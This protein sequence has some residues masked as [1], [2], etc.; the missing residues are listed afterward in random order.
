MKNA[1]TLRHVPGAWILTATVALTLGCGSSNKSASSG[2]DGSLDNSSGGYSSGA[3]S[4]SSGGSL[5]DGSSSGSSDAGPAGSSSGSDDGGPGDSSGGGADGSSGSSSGGSSDANSSSDVGAETGSTPTLDSGTKA[6][7][8]TKPD[9]GSSTA[10]VPTIPTVAWTSPYAGW[11]RGIPTDPTFFPIAVWLQLPSHA[12]ELA[13]LGVNIYLGNNAGTDPLMAGDLA[14][15]KGLGMYAI[16]GQDSVGLPNKDDTTIIGWWMSPDEP[17]NAQPDDGGYG[18][19]VPP[20][21]LVTE[22]NS[23]K[24]ADPTRPMYLGL[25]QGVAYPN[26]EGR[27][28][29]APAESGYVPASDIIAFDIY[30]YNNCSG[31]ANE[32]VTC[33]EFWLNATGIDNLHQWANRNQAAWTDFETTVINAG[34]TDGP[35]PVQTASEVWLALIHSANGVIYF[36]DSWNP[37]FRE[38]AI[39]E[40]TAMV[41]AVTALNQQIKSLAPELNSA[42]IPN[43]VAVASSN[44]AAPVDTMVKANGTSIY[45]FSAISRAGTATASYTIDGMTGN[46]VATVVGENRSVNVT[47]GKFSDSFAAN[48]VHI[49]KIDLSTA[50]CN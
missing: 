5:D 36:I 16:I 46:A 44:A 20:A 43:I 18:P 29:N 49:Y 3:T 50:T 24:T 42:N 21:T 2:A 27:G 41:T 38:D 6:D 9:S 10:C 13:N 30:P 14:T 22:Y 31:D 33:G 19:D 28:S 34:T 45:V 12:T 7:G 11:T 35:T 48:G 4:G 17:D 25:G 1:A 39:F 8:G 23:Y 40:S 26:Y 47:A 37:S 32:Q 15:L